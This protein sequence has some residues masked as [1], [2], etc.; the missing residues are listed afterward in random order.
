M[1]YRINSALTGSSGKDLLS[2]A[3]DS[4]AHVTAAAVDHS[5]IVGSAVVGAAAIGLGALSASF[6]L[7]QAIPNHKN[8]RS[9]F[10]S[11]TSTFIE[12]PE[13][14]PEEISI[15][16]K[17]MTAEIRRDLHNARMEAQ[18]TMDTLQ[19]LKSKLEKLESEN[20]HL[21]HLIEEKH[22]R[23]VSLNN[24]RKCVDGKLAK[25]KV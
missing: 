20:K 11:P 3:K 19:F 5:V 14:V 1:V 9:P 7:D 18:K 24:E 4:L 23:L 13:A 16:R 12:S 21:N 10:H 25:V 2:G 8:F 22:N 6:L 17:A 15:T